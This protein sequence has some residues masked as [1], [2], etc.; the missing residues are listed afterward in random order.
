MKREKL[1]ALLID[2]DNIP[3][4]SIDF[5]LSQLSAHGESIIRRAYGN[6]TSTHLRNWEKTLRN[7]AIQ[8]FQQFDLIKGKNAT[9]IA[10]TIDAMDI[11]YTKEVD[12]FCLATSD[13]DFS[14]LATRLRAEGKNVIG[15]GDKKTPSSFRQSCSTFLFFNQQ[16]TGSKA[17]PPSVPKERKSAKELKGNT[18]LMNTIRESI[19][20][21]ENE[22]GWAKLALIGS[23]MSA[24][25]SLNAAQFGY[26]KLIDLIQQIDK[27]ETRKDADGHWLVRETQ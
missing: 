13:C 2:A 17:Q 10:M 1:I 6:W 20:E 14:P 12:I 24:K 5:I 3:A 8:P 15:F 16:Q 25:A 22:E 23:R 21:T 9:D 19:R 26:K 7:H 4:E 27:F 18:K 11:L